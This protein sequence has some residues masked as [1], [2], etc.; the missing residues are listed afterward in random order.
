MM[1]DV[2]KMNRD[3]S[4]TE[5]GAL[6]SNDD[7]FFLCKYDNYGFPEG[8]KKQCG[9]VQ[10]VLARPKRLSWCNKNVD[11]NQESAQKESKSK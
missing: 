10:S 7:N 6:H 5:M 3:V 1:F 2:Q 11:R 4:S 9:G 8:K